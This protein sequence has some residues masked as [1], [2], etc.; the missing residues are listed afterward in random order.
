[1]SCSLW[2]TLK[3]ELTNIFSQGNYLYCIGAI[4]L[5]TIYLQPIALVGLIAVVASLYVNFIYLSDTTAGAS[6][7]GERQENQVGPVNSPISVF[8]RSRDVSGKQQQGPAE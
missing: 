2:S 8:N 1:M 7:E 6:R 5:L 3:W 4:A